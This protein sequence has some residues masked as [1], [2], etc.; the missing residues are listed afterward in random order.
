MSSSEAR[1]PSLQR[2]LALELA[3]AL[4]LILLGLF[5]VLDRLVAREL[6]ARMDSGLLDRAHTIIA[7][8]QAHPEPAELGEL[9]R[10]LP[11]YELPGHTDYFE[12]Q[13][14][15][16]ASLARLPSSGKH[17]LAR[18]AS[19]PLAGQA[20]YFD[21]PLPDQHG[22]R[23]VALALTTPPGSLA[24][25]ALLVVATEREP[26]DRLERRIHNLLLAGIGLTFALA[27]L[28]ALL[29][30]RRGLRPVL[31]V[32]DAV[33]AADPA[34]RSPA[35]ANL[36]VPRELEPF[37]Q[38]LTNAFER[39]YAMVES[40][41]RFS[42]DVA[43]ELRTPLAEIRSSIESAQRQPD[44]AAAT[45]AA[46][47][48]SIA[49][50][51]RMQRA[52]D[53]LFMLARQDAGLAPPAVDPLD[54]PPLLHGL[55]DGMESN[56]RTRDIRCLREL[57]AHLWIRCDVGA[58]ERI[59]S[60]LLHNAIEYAPAGS[61]VTVAVEPGQE[62]VTLCVSNAAPDL[63]ADDLA[64]LGQRFW[65]K[66]RTGGAAAHAGLGL[67]LARALARSLGLELHFNLDQGRLAARL[68][69][70]PCL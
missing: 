26:H 35:L 32:G 28:I 38:A 50:V 57:P 8:L 49:A 19:L 30:V 29:A 12:I 16:G 70:I 51:E 22:G 66:T 39:L 14:A 64:R 33:S 6:Y 5:L 69:R 31:R 15:A 65:R 41:R 18:P 67:A 48:A 40:E 47:A 43:H 37:A 53:V 60:N 24:H 13:D 4:G 10:L 45:R 17:R 55:L 44:D 46:F 1:A 56:A 2:R 27:V 42:R 54:L 59:V 20:L 52:I 21:L 23:A 9:G 61:L 7:F 3:L 62:T 11:E 63:D 58:L 68:A 34:A 36:T 25:P